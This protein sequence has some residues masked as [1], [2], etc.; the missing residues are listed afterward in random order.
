[1]RNRAEKANKNQTTR[2]ARVPTPGENN[3]SSKG[4][5]RK[6]E[7]ANLTPITMDGGAGKNY[8]LPRRRTARK[9]N[10]FADTMGSQSR[11]RINSLKPFKRQFNEFPPRTMMVSPPGKSAVSSSRKCL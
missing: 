9:N 3:S 1:V 5:I 4:K 8:L 11:G 7:K 2:L 6:D 10:K